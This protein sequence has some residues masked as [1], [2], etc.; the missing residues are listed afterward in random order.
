MSAIEWDRLLETLYQSNATDALLRP[1]SPPLIRLDGWR[2]LR[3]GAPLSADDVVV[4][5]ADRIGRL[6]DGELDGYSYRDF[7]YGEVAWF[8]A[9]AFD[10]P[11]TTLLIVARR[12][13]DSGPCDL[14]LVETSL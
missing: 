11:Q 14:K 8:R 3:V 2:A 6:A 13:K 10:Y 5:A 7:R 12:D 9:I 4:M 1:G